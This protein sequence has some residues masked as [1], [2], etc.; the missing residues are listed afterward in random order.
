MKGVLSQ[1]REEVIAV[2]FLVAGD[3]WPACS[4]TTANP[5]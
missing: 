1:L 2:A 5:R 4:A 3:P